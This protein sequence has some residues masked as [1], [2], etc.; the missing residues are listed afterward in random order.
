VEAE[1]IAALKARVEE[2]LGTEIRSRKRFPEK[3]AIPQEEGELKTFLASRIDYTLVKPFVTKKEVEVFCQ[4]AE[5]LKLFAVVVN[6]YYVSLCSRLL[7]GSGVTVGVAV[8]F[9]LGQTKPEIKAREARLAFQEGAREADMVIN[10]GALRSGE[11]RVVYQDIKGV[12]EEMSPGIVKVVLETCYLSE[13]E[14]VVGCFIAQAA[15]ACFV[16]TST[17]FGSR[18]ATIEDVAFLR[19]IVG[20]T[21]GIK[22]AGGV[23][24]RALA[25]HMIAHGAN[26]LG[27]S[28]AVPIVMGE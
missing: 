19:K 24:S 16:K 13:E 10:L 12:V 20:G 15:G 14:K 26:R 11:W 27:T 6:P 22:A 17:G 8:G 25:L 7:E 21:L 1:T 23:S 3:E 5:A 18:G 4:E 2:V 28:N 9:P